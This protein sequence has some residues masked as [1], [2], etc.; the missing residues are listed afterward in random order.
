MRSWFRRGGD[1]YGIVLAGAFAVLLI[2]PF[3]RDAIRPFIVLLFGSLLVFSLWTSDAHRR[4]VVAG[5][6]V[7]SVGVIGALTDVFREAD[8]AGRIV[9]SSLSV[10]FAAATIAVIMRRLVHHR[11]VSV[12]TITGSLSMYLLLGLLFAYL[13]VL[14][15]EIRDVIFF[16][17][18]GSHSPVAFLYFSF[19]TLT[20]VGYGDL[21]AG[22][23]AGRMLAVVEALIGQLY[24][25]TVVAVVIGNLRPRRRRR[26]EDPDEP[27]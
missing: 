6:V 23:D 27:S 7:T 18:P 19:V 17:Q 11:E 13:Y 24:L 20:T 2:A 22:D 16:A 3:E 12:R 26:G 9:F 25:V 5:L 4:V 8:R 10:L 15:A 14:E 21:T 1:E